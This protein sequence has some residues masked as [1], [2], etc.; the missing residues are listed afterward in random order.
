LSTNE[1]HNPNEKENEAVQGKE[2]CNG[3][4]TKIVT[5][6]TYGKLTKIVVN[7]FKV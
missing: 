4:L 5:K 2:R 1:V 3:K 7:I 6:F